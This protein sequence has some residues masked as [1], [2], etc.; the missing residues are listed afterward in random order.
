MRLECRAGFPRRRLQKKLLVSDPG[1]HHGTCVTHVPWC[2]SGPLTRGENVRGI[3]GVCATR[4][5]AYLVR[6]PQPTDDQ[7]HL[8][9]PNN[10]YLPYLV[11]KTMCL[12]HSDSYVGADSSILITSL[13][14]RHLYRLKAGQLTFDVNGS[15][16]QTIADGTYI[17]K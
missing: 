5:F 17:D 3:P 10:Q 11:S 2:M 12:M 8:C 14:T 6:G 1:M 15:I 9:V 4:N 13:L 7:R 16:A